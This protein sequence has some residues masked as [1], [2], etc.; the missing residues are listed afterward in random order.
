[1][2]EAVTLFLALLSLIALIGAATI[3]VLRV[4]GR[5]DILAGV[6]GQAMSLAAAVATVSTLGSLFMSE[7]AGYVPCRLCWVQ[8]GFMYPL[9][10]ILVVAAVQSTKNRGW[11]G[12]WKFGLPWSIAGAAVAAFHYSEQQG[13]VG[14]EGFCSATSPCTDIWVSHFGFISIPF[15]A[16][17]GF[18]F[19][20]A[21][22]WL[23][24]TSIRTDES[25]RTATRSD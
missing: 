23:H 24:A 12:I 8:R 20:A 14:G 7:V 25:T 3:V 16:F 1:M 15:M 5:N 6:T 22:M 21:L 10:V 2:T 11:T 9:A 19:V 18:V 13:W 17:A 4:I